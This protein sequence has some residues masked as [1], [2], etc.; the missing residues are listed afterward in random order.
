MR[1]RINNIG[2]PQKSWI[3]T[4]LRIRSGG[5]LEKG[6]PSIKVV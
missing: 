1:L 4:A 3:V 5:H 6:M 2:T